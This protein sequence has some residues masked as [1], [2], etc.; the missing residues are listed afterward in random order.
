MTSLNNKIIK[1]TK[2]SAITEIVAK[3]IIPI[4]N[5]MLARILA[6][7]AFGVVTT[8]TMI[9]SFADMFTDAGFQKYLI[10]HEFKCEKDKVVSTNVAFWSNLIISFIIWILVVIFAEEIAQMVG[11]PGLGNVISIACVQLPLTSFSSIQMSVYKRDFDFKTL[12]LVRLAGIFIPFFVTIPLAIL[13]YSYW[14]IIIGNIVG[15]FSNAFILTV[16]SKWKPKLNYSFTV[17][18]EMF[19]FSIWSLIESISIWLTTWIDTFIIGSVLNSYYLGVYKTSL[20]TVNGIFGIIT[21]STIPVLFSALSRVQNDDSKFN[22]IFFTTQKMVSYFV[23]PLSVGIFIY[24]DI[25]SMIF[26]GNGW[27]ESG[28]V[29]GIWGLMSGIVIVFGSYSSEVYRAKGRPKLSFMVQVL[30]IIVLVPVCI[31]GSR[32]NFVT[33]VRMRAIIRLQF[34]LIHLI[35]MKLYIGISTIDIFKNIRIPAICSIIMGITGMILRSNMKSIL[36][37]MISIF[38]CIICYFILLIS[39]QDSREDIL[40][41]IKKF[42]ILKSKEKDSNEFIS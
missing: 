39:F 38:I 22:N 12:F 18:K 37:E 8:I 30:H 5:M 29:I 14:S 27:T 11:N 23:L 28:A 40:K 16:K 10:Q 2:W 42:N 32:Y 17:L 35:F 19:D 6:P 33:L 1:A 20:T 36:G 3:L 31:I 41:Y 13:G 34:V 4:T 26:L 21:A 24:S 9:V 7:D 15:N 25:V